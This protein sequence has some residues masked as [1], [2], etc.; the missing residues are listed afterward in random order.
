MNNSTE[1]PS[2]FCDNSTT[3]SESSKVF[4]GMSCVAGLFMTT[5]TLFFLFHYFRKCSVYLPYNM[6]QTLIIFFC[7]LFCGFV[8]LVVFK[9]GEPFVTFFAYVPITTTV[10][11]LFVHLGN[12]CLTKRYDARLRGT[13]LV[14]VALFLASIQVLILLNRSPSFADIGCNTTALSTDTPPIDPHTK[15]FK[16]PFTETAML[17]ATWKWKLAVCYSHA[18]FVIVAGF[19]LSLYCYKEYPHG[20]ALFGTMLATLIF[21]IMY[22][23]VVVDVQESIVVPVFIACTIFTHLTLYG[24]PEI[25][26]LYHNYKLM[27]SEG[28][29]IRLARDML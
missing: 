9:W 7:G 23:C 12:L 17:T 29:D 13:F 25:L 3:L 19:F 18:G 1:V 2:V 26:C 5:P 10:S 6:I 16:L 15:L 27:Y 8:S 4:L 24:V 11:C 22:K 14:A 20:L 21:W 28:G